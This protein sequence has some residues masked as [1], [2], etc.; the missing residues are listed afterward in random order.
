[1]PGSQSCVSLHGLGE[2]NKETADLDSAHSLMSPFWQSCTCMTWPA[3]IL[4][5]W[6]VAK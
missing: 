6:I 2:A 4:E 3:A 5:C 1:M